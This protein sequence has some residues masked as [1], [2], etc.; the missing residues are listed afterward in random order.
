MVQVRDVVYK[1]IV[2]SKLP[3]FSYFILFSF[4]GESYSI[5]FGKEY[6]E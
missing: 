5:I 6:R 2:Q 4:Q 3:L 1:A